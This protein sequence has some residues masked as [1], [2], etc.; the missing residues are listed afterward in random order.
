MDTTNLHDQYSQFLQ[1]VITL[2]QQNI[3]C[4][5]FSIGPRDPPFVTPFVKALLRR[6][7]K[8]RRA[9]RLDQAAVL[10]EKN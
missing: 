3:P 10:A 6:R 2:V 4:H 1:V 5:T 7:N 9:G 8:L